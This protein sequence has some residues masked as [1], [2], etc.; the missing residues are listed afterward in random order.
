LTRRPPELRSN[1]EPA[2]NSGFDSRST[3][4]ADDETRFA[5]M[6]ICS[7]MDHFS[8]SGRGSEF[9]E[10][11]R[12]MCHRTMSY[13]DNAGTSVAVGF[14]RRLRCYL[15]ASTHCT[16]KRTRLVASFS[17]NFVLRWSQ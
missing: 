12:R 2:L 16:A 5:G 4:L 15:R 1:A 8:E 3:R 11:G 9:E 10:R 13:P 14:P 17:R 6:R 7:Y